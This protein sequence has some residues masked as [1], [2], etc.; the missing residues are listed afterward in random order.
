MARPSI[1]GVRVHVILPK[2]QKRALAALAKKTGLS[3][4][5]LLRR[6]VETFI[7][8]TLKAAV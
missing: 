1:H 3:E 7:L 8:A 4:S 5:E 6:A 2:I